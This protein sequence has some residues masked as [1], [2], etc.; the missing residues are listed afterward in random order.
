[1]F[2]VEECLWRRGRNEDHCIIV[3]HGTLMEYKKIY[4]DFW[5]NF[6]S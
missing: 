6:V 4:F 1:M 2:F 3:E 5:K